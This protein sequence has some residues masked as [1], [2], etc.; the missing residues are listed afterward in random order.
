MKPLLLAAALLAAAPLAPAAAQAPEPPL[1]GT[2]LDVV[3]TGEVQRVPDVARISAGVV[4]SAPTAT[5]ALEQNARRIAA[6]RA[7][8]KRAGIADRDIQTSAIN[9]FPDYRQDEHG[10]NPQLIGYRASNELAVRFRDLA[11]TGRILDA[12]VAVGA[13]QISGPTLAVDKPEAALDEARTLAVANAR[14]RA[15]LYARALGKR[16][17][18][19]VAVSEAGPVFSP[20]GKVAMQAMA[21]DSATNLIEPGEQA[22]AVSLNVTFELE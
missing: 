14:A 18:R 8:L 6:V 7:A 3:A 22:L 13:N 20:Y 10:G 11:N 2:R 1:R 9:L 12:L 4:T 15:E 16:V 21:R 5:A 17:G 19:V